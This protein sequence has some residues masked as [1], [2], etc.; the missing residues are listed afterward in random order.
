MGFP[1][2]FKRTPGTSYWE[3]NDWYRRHGYRLPIDVYMI[4]QWVCLIILD[5]GFFCFL[6][7]FITVYEKLDTQP[8]LD[9]TFENLNPALTQANN[10]YINPYTTWGCKISFYLLHLIFI[11]S[12]FLLL[13]FLN[14]FITSWQDSQLW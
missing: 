8:I 2:Q 13:L 9:T 4:M 10:S 1:F 7:H 5:V 14:L 6:V 12:L 11:R 3:K